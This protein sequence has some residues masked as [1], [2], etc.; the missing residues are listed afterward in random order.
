MNIYR[1]SYKDKTNDYELNDFNPFMLT[2]EFI[3]KFSK[4]M[5]CLKNNA[6][7]KVHTSKQ[8]DSTLNI[9]KNDNKEIYDFFQPIEKDKLFWCFY[10]LYNGIENYEFNKT[11]SFKIEK[12]FKYNSAEK[13]KSLKDIFKPLKLKINDLQDEFINKDCITFK[14]LIAF[15]YIYNVNILYIKNKTYYEIITNAEGKLNVIVERKENNI[16]RIYIPFNITND[17]IQL[18]KNEY[19]KIENLNNPLKSISSYTLSEL[20]TIS[21]C[22]SI[23]TNDDKKKLTKKEIYENILKCL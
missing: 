2:N 21:K 4:Q 18:Y 15:C 22:L 1:H 10:I 23:K 3:Y 14:G 13:I 19:W 12:E 7:N 5:N 20:Q 16:N 9:I 17:D 8:K 6:S 11:I